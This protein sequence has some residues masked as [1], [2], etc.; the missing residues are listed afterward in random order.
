M[1]QILYKIFKLALKI[2]QTCVVGLK[3]NILKSFII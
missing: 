1:Q 2:T 3:L